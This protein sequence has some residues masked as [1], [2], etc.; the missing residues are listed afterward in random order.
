L[1]LEANGTPAAMVTFI[2]VG[3]VR[4]QKELNLETFSNHFGNFG[5]RVSGV[6]RR[7][8]LPARWKLGTGAGPNLGKR[9]ASS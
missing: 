4:G 2:V 7:D 5:Y 1:A 3:P 6:Q 8:E 9:I